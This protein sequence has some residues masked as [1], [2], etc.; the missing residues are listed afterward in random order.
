M[1][2]SL[3]RTGTALLCLALAATATA[4]DGYRQPPAPIAQILDAERTPL[5]SLSPDRTTML[6]VEWHDMP[7][8]AELAAPEA[9]LAGLRINPRTNAPSRANS[10]KGLRLQ[11]IGEGAAVTERRIALPA[12]ARVWNNNWSPDSRRIALTML[13]DTGASLWLVDVATATAREVGPVRLNGALGVPCSWIDSAKL[14]C[15]LV[16]AD[17]G[18]SPGEAVVPAGPIIQQSMG[19]AAANRTYQDLL[20]NPVDEARFDHLARSQIAVVSTDGAVMPI[21]QPGV[22]RSVEPS[23]DGRYLIVSSVQRPYSY[24]LP[25][26]GFPTT[27]AVWD[28]QGNVVKT[29]AELP[30]MDEV[31]TSFDAVPKGIRDLQWRSDAP[32]TLV[33]VEALDE[34]DPAKPVERRDRVY[35][36][37]APFSGEPTALLDV[38]TRATTFRWV[39]PD[40]ALIYEEWWRTRRTKTWAVDPSNPGSAPRLVFDRSSE[41]RY[42]HPGSFVTVA[43]GRYG[44]RVVLTTPDGRYAYL[45]GAGASPEGDRP[46]LDRVEL[47]TGRKERLWRSAAPHYETV[48]AVLDERASRI[49]TQRESVQD[50]PNYFMRDLRANNT[51]RLTS[52]P[53][54][55]PQF[56]SVEPKLITYK[57]ADGVQLSAK[58]Y[59]P[60]GYTPARGPLPFL[61]WAYPEEFRSAAAAAQVV[62]SPYRF[63]R[64][65]R[66]SHLFLLTQGYGVLDGPTMPI[67]GEGDREPN[68][69]YIEQLVA[70]AKA[71]VDEVVRLGVADRHRIA[72]GGHSYGA[73]MTANLLAHSDL[74]RAG[75]ARSGAYNRTLTPFGFQ[76]EERTFWQARDTYGA[77]SPFYHADKI[78]EP[79]LLIHGEADNNSGTFPIQSERMYAALMGNKGTVRYVVLPAESHG[80]TARESVGH[81]LWEMVNWLDTY[82][83]NAPRAAAAGTGND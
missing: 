29:L 61:F 43:G 45:T 60:P 49:L 57:R 35:M 40:L 34:G 31:G 7:S 83:K 1:L 58:L 69:T 70:S 8:I 44:R 71:A 6:L 13:S 66:T 51:R 62:G 32:A 23:P 4:Q 68:D 9:R 80:Y 81:T 67:V 15:R 37:D 14:V 78:N 11:Q 25:V 76:A 19:R 64:P 63:V 17:R 72:V 79:I 52:F 39:R 42:A 38:A 65:S 56:A 48:E 10:F 22:F 75:I 2:P 50:P 74:F 55:A 47:A 20:Q 27:L 3:I 46:F 59:L 24:I 77:M 82:V 28:L 73:F 53:D 5:L 12:G 18:A 54:P 30:L 26:W 36:H 41:D 16:P 33:W 21:G